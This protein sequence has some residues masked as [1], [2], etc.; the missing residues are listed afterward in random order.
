MDIAEGLF[1]RL[2]RQCYAVL[3]LGVVL[4][5][6]TV[7]HYIGTEEEQKDPKE[8][9]RRRLRAVHGPSFRPSSACI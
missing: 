1:G 7:A 2:A 9:T 5:T 8:R 6:A 4:V 3:C